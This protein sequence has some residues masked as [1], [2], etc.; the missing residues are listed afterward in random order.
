MYPFSIPIDEHVPLQHF[1]RWAC[2]PSAFRQMNLYPLNF[3]WQNI[4]SWLITDIFNNTRAGEG[5]APPGVTAQETLLEISA[6]LRLG[7]ACSIS[8]A[9]GPKLKKDLNTCY[10]IKCLGKTSVLLASLSACSL[11][12][13]SWH[14]SL[15]LLYCPKKKKTKTARFC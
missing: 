5:W 9:R 1:E 11:Q 7:G 8:R 13:A 14:N 10:I 6:G 12:F 4:L 2:T 15:S 3:L